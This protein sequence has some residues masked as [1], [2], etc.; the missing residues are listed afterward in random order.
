MPDVTTN[1][2]LTQYVGSDVPK[3]IQ[4]EAGA[5]APGSYNRD[6]RVIDA[7]LNDLQNQVDAVLSSRLSSAAGAVKAANIDTDAVVRAKIKDLEVIE[8]KLA[9]GAVTTVKIGD[10]QVT[11]AKIGNLQVTTAKIADDAVT[12]DKIG[13]SQ[14]LSAHLAQATKD[15][16]G[17]PI[18][19]V[20]MRLGV[21]DS[22]YIYVDGVLSPEYLILNGQTVPTSV[23]GSL[24]SGLGLTPS[25]GSITLPNFTGRGPVG[26]GDVD[27][28]NY[29]AAVGSS[30]SSGE[31]IGAAQF[32]MTTG[33]LPTH[34]HPE[35]HHTHP[36]AAHTHG[37]TKTVYT[38]RDKFTA[39][40][41]GG[42]YGLTAVGDGT[43]NAATSAAGTAASLVTL[44]QDPHLHEGQSYFNG[45]TTRITGETGSS[46]EISVVQPSIGVYFVVKAK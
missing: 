45:D 9:D 12:S 24:A 10:S 43:A 35:L 37:Y 7:A 20:I 27:A 31:A 4:A 16:L 28:L 21:S 23:Y 15:A 11:T 40:S 17:M 38:A 19:T 22:P 26:A 41:S 18:G 34:K 39:P 46:E 3:W 1:Y 25:G 5:S 29:P 44:D 8:S 13:D 36:I 30:I 2:D 6:M 32:V 42:V 14:I 33:Q